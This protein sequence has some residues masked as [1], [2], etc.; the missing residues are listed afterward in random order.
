VQLFD[1]DKITYY[2][3][4]FYNIFLLLFVVFYI[5]LK[6]FIVFGFLINMLLLDNLNYFLKFIFSLLLIF[7]IL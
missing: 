4:F 7:M 6:T 1:F 3:Y 5:F 2:T